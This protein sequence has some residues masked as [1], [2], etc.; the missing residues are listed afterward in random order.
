VTGS[1]GTRYRV[2]LDTN[3]VVRALINSRSASGRVLKACE[4]RLLVPLL[5]KSVLSEYRAV[6]TEPRIAERYPGLDDHSI[7][8]AL[9][10]LS[11]V[12]DLV[13]RVTARFEFRRDPKDAKFI[14]LA[15]TARATHLIT[16]DD[17]L[18]HLIGGRDDASKRFRQRLPS[19]EV[20]LPEE[21]VSRHINDPGLAPENS[22]DQ[23]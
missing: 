14:E 18:L 21:F 12:G 13:R 9:E 6:L 17:D 11:Y 4:R 20:L 3:V 7:R 5:S 15:I 16:T 23:R 8:A 19:I 1:G 2:V 10:R 22:E